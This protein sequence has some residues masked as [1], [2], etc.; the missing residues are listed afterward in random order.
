MRLLFVKPKHI[1]DILLLT[2]TLAATRAAHP[3]AEIWVIV[4][5]GTEGILA[6]CPAIDHLITAPAP[7]IKTGRGQ[8][9]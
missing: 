7:E 9:G 1:G 5:E 2:P 3:D 4:R 8:T 6:G